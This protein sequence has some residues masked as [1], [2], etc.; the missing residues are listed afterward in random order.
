VI[1]CLVV[2]HGN[3]GAELIRLVELILGPVEGLASLSNENCSADELTADIKSWLEDPAV[4]S[5]GGVLVLVDSFGSSCAT[6]TQIA[7]AAAENC[8]I[9]SGV[10][11]ALLLG[12]A[13]RR[14]SLPLPQLVSELLETGRQ[15]ITQLNQPDG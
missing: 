5:A 8:A 11:L 14:D 15:A 10:N 7:C 2:T 12:Y 13:T 6:T 4:V 9:I 3:L 1:P